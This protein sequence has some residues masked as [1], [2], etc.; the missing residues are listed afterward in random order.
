MAH[1]K[2]SKDIDLYN[3]IVLE[4]AGNGY[5]V[6]NHTASL[7]KVLLFGCVPLAALSIIGGVAFESMYPDADFG[8]LYADIISEPGKYVVGLIIRLV[9][10]VVLVLAT[11]VIHEGLHACGF[12]LCAKTTWSDSV[13]F[14]FDR[15]TFSPYCHAKK[16]VKPVRT[17]VALL[18]PLVVLGCGLYV[19]A[20]I[21]GSY[22]VLLLSVINIIGSGGDIYYA[23]MLMRYPADLVLD[24][25]D[26]IGFTALKKENGKV[27]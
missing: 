20:M 17:I 10:L 19:I 3:N 8:F 1:K 9:V 14:G 13:S 23:G 7:A 6:K 5:E 22:V 15:R 27:S 26:S 2:P 16:P 25:P 21:C 12:V 11:T 18:L 4:Y 24:N